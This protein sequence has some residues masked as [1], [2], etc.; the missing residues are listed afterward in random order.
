MTMGSL[1]KWT[2]GAL[3]GAGLL[4]LVGAG[5]GLDKTSTPPY[6]GPSELGLSLQMGASPDLINADGVSQSVVTITARDQNGRPAV[7]RLIYITGQ[8]DGALIA[9]GVL[10]GPLQTGFTVATGSNGIAQ[11]VYQ[12]GFS[13]TRI[14]IQARPYGFD[15]F[16]GVTREVAIDQ[17]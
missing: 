16:A 14:L 4:A 15:A 2:R 7:N 11:V 10:V 8:G 13:V 6:F 1:R 12:A 17:R 5:C 3:G 9:G